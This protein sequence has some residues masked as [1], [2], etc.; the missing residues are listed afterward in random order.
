MGSLADRSPHD[1][2]APRQVG[3]IT[4]L[5]RP[6]APVP[7][8]PYLNLKLT[9]APLEDGAEDTSPLVF[10]VWLSWILNSFPISS[11]LLPFG[12]LWGQVARPGI[13]GL[14]KFRV[15][16]TGTLAAF[17]VGL[18]SRKRNRR[19]LSLLSW[20]N[21]YFLNLACFDVNQYLKACALQ[22][23]FDWVPVNIKGLRRDCHFPKWFYQVALPPGT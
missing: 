20:Y 1:G 17:S 23:Y 9:S 13:L 14:P 2:T 8:L 4:L 18:L 21:L 10:P 12:F 6:F 3:L 19:M 15:P 11:L 16:W 22:M 7:I 5:F